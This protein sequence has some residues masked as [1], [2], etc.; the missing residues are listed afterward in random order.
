MPQHFLLGVSLTNM[1]LRGINLPRDVVHLHKQVV[2]PSL[3]QFCW[4]GVTKIMQSTVL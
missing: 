3:G 1:T 4:D 2:L